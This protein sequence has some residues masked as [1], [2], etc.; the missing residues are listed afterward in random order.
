MAT[1]R[2][3]HEG[4]L[5]DIACIRKYPES[6][7]LTRARAHTRECALSGH[8]ME[9]GYG[10]V[11]EDRQ[12]VLLDDAATPSVVSVIRGSNRD[13]GIRL[14]VER[15]MEDSEMRTTRVEEI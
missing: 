15:D 1:Q 3:S 13:R 7:L 11:R 14:R 2:E 8:C 12:V 6:E 5:V 4:Y 9:S 10:L